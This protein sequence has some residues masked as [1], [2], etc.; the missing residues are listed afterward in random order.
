MEAGIHLW[1]VGVHQLEVQIH[2]LEVGIHLSG[3]EIHLWEVG[4]HLLEAGI[5]L[6]GVGIHLWE[7]GIHLLEAG[8][9]LSGIKTP[10]VIWNPPGEGRTPCVWSGNQFVGSRNP[11][12]G[13]RNR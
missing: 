8:I 1:G 9:H 2:L 6:S 10:S 3:E 4:I 11:S 7:V 12:F 5:H 13:S